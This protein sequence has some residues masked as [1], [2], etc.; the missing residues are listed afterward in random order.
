MVKVFE[1]LNI[2]VNYNN[3][4]YSDL[5]FSKEDKAILREL[6][7]EVSELASKPIMDEKKRLWTKHNKLEETRPVIL[8]DPENGWNEIITEDMVKCK[9]DI[10]R[11]WEVTL[12]KLIFWGKE[13][14][15]DYVIEPVFDVPHVYKEQNWT[16]LDYLNKRKKDKEF[17]VSSGSYKDDGG[18]YEIKAILED[19]SDL[20]KIVEPTIEVDYDL[21]E[22]L[23]SIAKEIF[24][25]YLEARI[26]TVWFWSAG[27]LT[28]EL[29][30]LRGM[31]NIFY[32]F[33]DYP[34]ELHQLMKILRDGTIKKLKFF[35]SNNLLSTNNDYGFVGSG[36]LGYIDTLPQEDFAGNI[37]LKDMWGLAESQITVGVS[38]EM[39][40]E[41]IFPYQKDIMEL[42][43]LTCYGCC[44]PMDDRFEIVKAAK[45]LRRVSVSPWADKEI[46]AELLGKDYIYSA[47]LSPSY[48]AVPNMDEDVV[49]DEIRNLLKITKDKTILELHMKDNHTLGN[50]PKNITRWVEIVREEIENM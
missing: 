2:R 23:L 12:R 42:F 9:N 21:T 41:F 32:D 6:G 38:P 14:N 29:A 1:H 17:T 15:D 27:G 47:K 39:F 44:E 24:D 3:A 34:D 45:N 13:M 33:Y 30:F 46:M 20:D 36:G 37:R 5:N 28:D 16:T 4:D 31:D 35:E 19:Y 11:H 7:K 40:K 50:N 48:L 18:S 8:A 43:G 25:G 22:Q 26:R 49:R 10:A